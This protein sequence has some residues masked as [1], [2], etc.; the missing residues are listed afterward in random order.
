MVKTFKKSTV[1]KGPFR[2]DKLVIGEGVELTAPEGKYLTLTLNG[3]GLPLLPGTYVGDVKVSVTD[4]HKMPWHGLFRAMF[5][6][7]SE[8]IRAAVV[9]DDNELV[10]NE[11]M[12][13]VI[14]GGSYDGYVLKDAYIGSS[15]ESFNGVL[16]RG[17]SQYTIANSR[18]DFENQ[19][20]N[21]FL[22]VGAGVAAL[23][24]ARVRVDN[25]QFTFFDG[26]TR[27]AVHV[28]GDS[29][30][31][32]NNSR[33]VNLS[34]YDDEYLGA[35]AWSAG[36]AG[37]NR[38]VQL[39]DNGTAYYNNCDFIGNG[40]G[41]LS[42]D[43]CDDCARYFIKNCRLSVAGPRSTSYGIFCIGDRNIVSLDNC[44][45]NVNGFPL[46]IMGSKLSRA[47][48]EVINGSELTGT[49]YGV[50]FLLDHNTKTYIA[51]SSIITGKSSFVIKGSPVN[52]RVERS[53]LKPANGTICQLMANDNVPQMM[54][55]NSPVV[56]DRPDEYIPGRDLGAIDPEMD[57][58]LTFSDMDLLGNFYNSTHNLHLEKTAKFGTF[59]RPAFGGA[60]F[61]DA[62]MP[63]DLSTASLEAVFGQDDL[64][65]R[66]PKNLQINLQKTR[67]EGVASSATE[68]HIDDLEEITER[69]RSELNNV[70]QTPAPTVNNGVI[71]N[72]DGES[73][74]IVTGVCYITA[75][76]YMPG[77]IIKARH[78]RQLCITVDGRTVEL[79]ENGGELA[80]KIVI[81]L[82]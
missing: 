27:C 5:G 54:V 34:Y 22:G 10:K 67:F 11:C 61:P 82:E 4:Y 36:F 75:L 51:D 73:T 13:A 60:L 49:E 9:V 41:G 77:S 15:E 2:A 74:W 64:D 78:G 70:I 62:S 3:K 44:K 17:N 1:I 31:E 81:S 69:T 55:L 47:Y 59:D 37:G 65:Q 19:G 53:V 68:R 25:C 16:V 33:I 14:K 24:N 79:D 66:G 40:W 38:L 18:F 32:V 52:I 72:L 26:R 35:F 80:G 46:I 28:A 71:V 43:G 30:V 56:A 12:T 7:N 63:F 45:F 6:D 58:V 8:D 57:C 48:T 23:D 42:I 20:R 76:K 39:C 21:D 50:F 29:I